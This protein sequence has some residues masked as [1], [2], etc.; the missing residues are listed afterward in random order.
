MQKEQKQDFWEAA[1]P[2]RSKGDAGDLGVQHECAGDLCVRQLSCPRTS[3]RNS[4]GSVSTPPLVASQG[5]LAA[6]VA[7]LNE[8]GQWER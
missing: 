4:S 7:W 8:G 5:R 3:C 1:C 2:E 6:W